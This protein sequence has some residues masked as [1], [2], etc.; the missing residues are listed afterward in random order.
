MSKLNPGRGTPL[1]YALLLTLAF[2]APGT[3][4]AAETSSPTHHL[5]SLLTLSEPAAP[6]LP[7]I[8]EWTLAQ[9]TRVLFVESRELPM[10]DVAVSFAA[11]S[12]YDDNTPG[13]AA[14]TMHLLK[15][16]TLSR[17]ANALAHAFDQL[18]VELNQGLGKERTTIGLRSLSDQRIRDPAMQLLADMLANPGF[19]ETG[20]KRVRAEVEALSIAEL[21]N[22]ESRALH[23]VYNA[24][25]PRQPIAQSIYGSPKTLKR[26]DAQ[27]LRD[28]HRRAYSSSNAQISIVG[29]LSAEQARTISQQ[30]AE[31]LPTGPALA[32]P[33]P[34]QGNMPHSHIV[35]LEDNIAQS[36]L[37]LGQNALS[38]HHPDSMATR[39]GHGIF[40]EILNAQLREKHSATY[41]V[42]SHTFRSNHAA[43]WVISLYTPPHYSA[44]AAEQVTRLYAKF[45]RDGPTEDQVTDI[46]KALLRS[47][48]Q[49]TASNKY[50]LAEMVVLNRFNQPLDFSHKILRVQTLTREQIKTAMARHFSADTWV[51]LTLG[52][53][54]AQKPLPLAEVLDENTAQSC[55]SSNFPLAPSSLNS[56]G[57]RRC[58]GNL[59]IPLYQSHD[60]NLSVHLSC[61]CSPL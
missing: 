16:G 46:K 57:A 19:S 3:S 6:T 45:L 44:S 20:V 14:M 40:D 49:F 17:D 4:N 5:E 43:P 55:I 59:G 34:A 13:L 31:A 29:D 25:Y 33:P 37:V 26:I 52:P 28:F 61:P 7:T 38:I 42:I 39:I 60:E 41:G 54:V 23:H 48:P 35:H 18:G 9:N 56:W 1:L 50:T 36:L 10:I 30:L 53:T 47:M 21:K 24:L 12:I 58:C 51:K 22:P 11:G 8:Q 32:E 2:A 15:E 27:Q